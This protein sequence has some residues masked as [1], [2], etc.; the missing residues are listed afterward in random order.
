MYLSKF[1]GFMSFTRR[2]ACF[3]IVGNLSRI[4]AETTLFHRRHFVAR[5][6]DELF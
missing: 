2:I 6:A 3:Q 5:V 1:D 4:C